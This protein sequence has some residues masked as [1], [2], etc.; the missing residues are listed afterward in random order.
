[1]GV[2]GCFLF[3]FFSHLNVH[4]TKVNKMPPRRMQK[5][6]EETERVAD[7]PTG[8]M[9]LLSKKLLLK[10]VYF[11]LLLVLDRRHLGQ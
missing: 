1:M 8:H 5:V 11:S 2:W 6:R 7:H 9:F 10:T 4:S 3:V